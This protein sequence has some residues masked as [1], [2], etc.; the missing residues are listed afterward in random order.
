MERWVNNN[1]VV[2]FIGVALVVILVYYW[3][4]NRETSSGGTT[5]P[6]TGAGSGVQGVISTVPGMPGDPVVM[7]S[8]TSPAQPALQAAFPLG[9]DRQGSLIPGVDMVPMQTQGVA[10]WQFAPRQYTVVAGDTLRSVAKKVGVTV[11]T[12]YNDNRVTLSLDSARN[13]G[14]YW[15]TGQPQDN[16]PANVKLYPGTTLNF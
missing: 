14:S 16:P 8:T 10:Q 3:W 2:V 1:K 7:G 15:D 12:L 6:D 9:R 13:G 11:Q 4:Q 5:A